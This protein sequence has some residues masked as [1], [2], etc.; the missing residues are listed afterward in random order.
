MAQRFVDVNGHF[1]SGSHLYGPTRCSADQGRVAVPTPASASA[2]FASAHFAAGY[3]RLAR[4][5]LVSP[6]SAGSGHSG[7]RSCNWAQGRHTSR[8]CAG[9]ARPR[10]DHYQGPVSGDLGSFTPSTMAQEGTVSPASA[11]LGPGGK[12]QFSRTIEQKTALIFKVHF[13]S[14]AR[15]TPASAIHG[16]HF[17]L[18]L[19]PHPV[20]PPSHPPTPTP[21]PTSPGPTPT[22]VSP[23][24][25]RPHPST[26]SLVQIA[27]GSRQAPLVLEGSARAM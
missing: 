7:V 2:L 10:T 1:P 19:C 11:K 22:P 6:S 18:V 3:Q 16:S 12:L 23:P 26:H 27:P 21:S 17:N 9:Y 5:K 24:V 14:S 13:E 20:D 15:P 25:A 4:A 8:C